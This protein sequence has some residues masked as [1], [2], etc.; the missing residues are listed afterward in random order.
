V[1]DIRKSC[2]NR[3]PVLEKTLEEFHRV[4]FPD[5]NVQGGMEPDQKGDGKSNGQ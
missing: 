5:S 3:I 2:L 4:H 1:S